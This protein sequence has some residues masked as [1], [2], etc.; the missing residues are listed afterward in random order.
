M[1]SIKLLLIIF[2]LCVMS[3]V[4]AKTFKIS[5]PAPDGSF[6]MNQMR[7]GAKEVFK[8]TQGRVKF[9][10]YPGGV[11]GSE[12]VAL[13]KIRIG[14]LQ[15]VAISNGG[16]QKI[17]PDSQVYS[18]PMIFNSFEEVDYVRSILDEQIVKGLDKGGMVSFGLSE[19]GFTFAMSMKPIKETKDLDQHKFWAPINNKQAEITLK[20]FGVTPIPL[21]FGD[22]LT[23]LQTNLIDTIVVSPITAI[24]LQWHTQIK[25]ITKV[26]LTYTYAT[27]VIDDQ[28]IVKDIMSNV[29]NRLDKQNRKDN[30]AA[31]TAMENQG[32]EIIL[33]KD[34]VLKEWYKKGQSS[35]N[36]IKNNNILSDDV[37]KNI[38]SLLSTYR[39]KQEMLGEAK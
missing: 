3:V 24:A 13:K 4:Q 23:G 25:F 9:K 17:Y 6:W 5:T 33:P 20:S 14:Q 31:L 32:V 39:K 18:L 35:R 22:V 38:T 16:L 19:G 11:M 26:P 34:K 21:S 12:S 10:Y 28:K 2:S 30:I 1:K 29:F 7:A 36:A 37:Y 8:A 27:L 15:G